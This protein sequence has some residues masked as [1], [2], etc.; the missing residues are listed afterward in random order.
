M[1]CLILTCGLLAVLAGC[2]P[3]ESEKT[4]QDADTGEAAAAVEEICNGLD[5]NGDGQ[6]DE[7]LSR[8]TWYIDADG[9]GRGDDGDTVEDC[10][11]PAG[12]ASRGGD[13]DDTNANISPEANELCNGVDDD[14]DGEIDGPTSSDAVTRFPDFDGDGYG[15]AAERTCTPDAEGWVAESL[16]LDCDDTDPEV[17]PGSIE[18][19]NGVDDDCDPSTTEA[20]TAR[21][22]D[23]DGEVHHWAAGRFSGPLA[24]LRPGTLLLCSGDFPWTLRPR[25]DLHIQAAPEADPSSRPH[26]DAS[27]LDGP[28]LLLRDPALTVTVAGID[29]TGGIGT[30]AISGELTGGGAIE[31]DTDGS[32]FLEDVDIQGGLADLGGGVL[33][34]GGATFTLVDSQLHD[35]EASWAGGALAV[36]DGTATLIDTTVSHS[37]APVGAGLAAVG[38]EGDAT[39]ELDASVVSGNI[40]SRLAGGAYIE[41]AS[42]TCLGDSGGGQGIV[43]NEAPEGGGMWMAHN[44]TAEL[45]DCDLGTTATD[46]LFVDIGGD[47]DGNWSASYDGPTT[48]SCT[49]EGCE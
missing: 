49:S 27:S 28:A 16:G 29:L 3:K 9:D 20:G 40:A 35:S 11:Q 23:V 7:G 18:R 47:A 24:V 6:V 46:N 26:L 42:L 39:V 21:L 10:A 33:V 34:R 37:S 43:S 8:S 38:L 4:D 14:C 1:K 32:L 22:E 36:I 19:C 13:C 5:D 48:L 25:V 2:A 30:A 45:T 44:S 41:H 31:C 17:H 12:T 15:L